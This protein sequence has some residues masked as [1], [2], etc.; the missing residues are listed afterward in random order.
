MEAKEKQLES[1]E[2]V[3]NGEMGW[4]KRVDERE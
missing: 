4:Q 2:E 3:G 1:G